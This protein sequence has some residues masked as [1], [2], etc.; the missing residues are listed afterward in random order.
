MYRLIVEPAL[1]PP[2]FFFVSDEAVVATEIVLSPYGGRNIGAARDS[3][4]YHL[5]AM[6]QCI[7]R[8]F[9]LL[10]HLLEA[11]LSSP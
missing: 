10:T 5:S 4:N 9:G 8:A 2:Q 3:F 11:S 6:R 1:L 7:E